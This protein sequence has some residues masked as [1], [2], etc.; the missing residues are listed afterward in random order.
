MKNILIADAGSTKIEWAIISEA[1]VEEKRISTHGINA[2]LADS[3]EIASLFS[4][5]RTLLC[6]TESFKEIHYYGAG[7]ATASI[8]DKIF[9]AL[10]ETWQAG[11]I[12][13]SSDLLGAARALLGNQSGIACIL[14]TGSNSCLYD[15]NGIVSNVPSLGFILGDEGSG[16]A[17]GKR[18]IADAFKG[19]LPKLVRDR[20]LSM[21]ELTLEEILD[22]TYRRPAANRFLASLVPF[23]KEH[24]WNPYVYSLIR[25]E[26][27]SFLRR[28]VAMYKGSHTLPLTFTGS[29]AYHFS[30][31]LKETADSLGLKVNKIEQ[32]PMDGLIKFHS[33][34]NEINVN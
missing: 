26:F 5:A 33:S 34:Q 29:I 21:Y 32:A 3:A 25:E 22:Y 27:I 17:L 14:G 6:Q 11:Y 30:D 31:I 10:S 23:L 8:C 28:N 20:F 1:G 18:L 12:S 9:K 15:G 2:L 7:C 4:K 24:L 16:A 19:H 13:V